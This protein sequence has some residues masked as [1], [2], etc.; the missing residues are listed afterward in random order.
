MLAAGHVHDL[1][2]FISSDPDFDKSDFYEQLWQGALWRKRTWFM[3]EAAEMQVMYYD[4]AAYER[5]GYSEP[6]SRW[7][8]A[9]MA[10]DVTS[11]VSGQ[12]QPGDLAWGFLDVGMDSLFSYAYN[13]NNQCSETATVYCQTPLKTENIAAALD[14]YSQMAGRPGQM[15][16]LSTELSDVF[17]QTQLSAMGTMLD[18]DRQA[19]LLLN[20][21]G[22]RRKVA[23]WV[24]SAG[25]LR[26]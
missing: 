15:P 3:P 24:D 5:A 4:K 13:W 22:S 7:T 14:W 11:I 2:D 12:P 20:F 16:D 18:V 26:V 23:I 19:L 6:S 21:Q 9:E 1:N 8:W 10:Q 17:S 25:D